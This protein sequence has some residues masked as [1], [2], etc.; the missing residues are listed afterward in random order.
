[1]QHL[2][3]KKAY[4]NKYVP[5]KIIIATV[6]AILPQIAFSDDTLPEV[7]V[8]TTNIQSDKSSEKTK[9][10]TVNSTVSATRL[11]T[12]LPETPQ[13]ISIIT[14]ELIDDFKLN[15]VNDV[16]DYATGI[17]VERFEPTR[18]N[19]T[20]RGSYITNFQIDGLGTPFAQGLVF[21]DLDTAT[22]DRIEV[23]RGANGLLTGTGNPSATIN[24]IRKRPTKDFRAKVGVSAGSWDYRR[25]DVDV[26]GL[27]NEM[28]SLRGRL[29]LA[30]MNQDS[31]LD[32]Y[33]MER[34]V[35]YGIIEVD[36]TNSTQV[37]LG[38]TYQ[39]HDADGNMWGSYPL[40]N[41]DGTKR[42]FK[43]SDSTVPNWSY[44]DTAENN[45]FAELTH[46]F[47]NEWKLKTQ[48][49][50]KELISDSRILY[51]SQDSSSPTNLYA[52]LGK[53]HDV[54]NEWVADA[55]VSGPFSLAGRKHELVFGLN[56]SKS[57]ITE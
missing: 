54:V 11:D 32:R 52:Y 43:R 25:L 3:S 2:L 4:T 51:A 9:S 18:T 19:Y 1:M 31:Y 28:G 56:W 30:N 46:Y 29:V 53:Y 13:S 34:N 7:A 41:D 39:K 12:S 45:T 40:L 24:F 38:H 27:L 47:D 6:T 21:G 57:I 8:T 14:R 44:W 36:I 17:K 5:Q 22:Y 50:R 55:Y 15:N 16:L 20:A 10:Y 48:V 23:L 42:N 33:S 35:A 49:T 37:A 26:S